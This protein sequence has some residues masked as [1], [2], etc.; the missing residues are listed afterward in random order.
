MKIITR[1][2]KKVPPQEEPVDTPPSIPSLPLKPHTHIVKDGSV[3]PDPTIHEP[4][5]NSIY[6]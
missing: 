6:Q 5:V 3:I 1:K 2:N 4:G